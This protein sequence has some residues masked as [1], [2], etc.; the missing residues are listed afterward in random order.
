M[1]TAPASHCGWLMLAKLRRNSLFRN[2]KASSLQQ[3]YCIL[4]GHYIRYFESDDVIL[5]KGVFN[6]SQYKIVPAP[7]QG[8]FSARHRQTFHLIS[9]DERPDWVLVAESKESMQA[10]VSAVEKS[11]SSAR[12]TTPTTTGSD[13]DVLGKWLQRVDVAH[14]QHQQEKQRT[15][16]S[17]P[18][19]QRE[20]EDESEEDEE[21]S[22]MSPPPSPSM[23][24]ASSSSSIS[25]GP[26]SP[27]RD[28]DQHINSLLKSIA[29]RRK[30]SPLLNQHGPQP[31]S[32]TSPVP[33]SS[34]RSY[35]PPPP[36]LPLPALYS[37][38]H[39]MR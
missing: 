16:S 35:A 3:Y 9:G 19:K 14:Q 10:W 11:T 31:Q 39:R 36:P 34:S 29:A 22:F 18:D 21:E 8:W 33:P 2:Q 37:G 23:S 5:P 13:D 38:E 17:S 15:S 30:S 28:N 25:A 7:R 32:P 12:T 4:D 26:A 24:T 27:T 1:S 20:D 6:L